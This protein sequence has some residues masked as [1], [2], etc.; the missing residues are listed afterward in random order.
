MITVIGIVHSVGDY[1]GVKYDNYNLHCTF[2]PAVNNNNVEGL[3]TDVIKIKASTFMESA[4]GI[5]DTIDVSYD[6]FGRIKDICKF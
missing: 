6:K 5:G 4:I 3:M 2:E 1:N